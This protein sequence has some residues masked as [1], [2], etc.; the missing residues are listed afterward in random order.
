MTGTII[1]IGDE[2]LIGQVVNTNASWISGQLTAIGVDVRSCVTCADERTDIS[3]N[4]SH[5]LEVT[6]IV[7]VTGGLGPTDDDLTRGVVADLFECPLEF[8]ADV[9]EDVCRLFSSRGLPM[10][11]SNR[12]Q[13]MIPQGFEVL[14]NPVGTAPGFFRHV[15]QRE[16]DGDLFVLPGVPYEMKR[17]INDHVLP[18][19]ERQTGGRA[20]V[21]KTLLTTGI[22]ESWLASRLTD[23]P[24]LL[25]ESL[26]L[27]YLPSVHGVRLRI[28]AWPDRSEDAR[29][30]LEML[31]S[32]LR[33]RL[34]T[35]IYSSDN[36]TLE[37]VVGHLLLDQN[38]TVSIAESCTGG[39][40][41]DRL[42][43]VPGSSGYFSGS[44]TAYANEI[45]TSVLGVSAE[46]IEQKGA[47]SR[48]VAKEMAVKIR[49]LTGSDVS[50]S[51]TGIMGPGGGTG[52]K[53]VGT[54]WIGVADG[55][56]CQARR[57][58]FGDDRER[59]KTRA[60]TWAL[61]QLRILLIR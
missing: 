45:K 22:G 56:G 24:E 58:R 32:L 5:A 2:L 49:S 54:V 11:D 13:A 30:R 28:T 19:L 29:D 43:N 6:D 33:E 39:R 8:D 59:N 37:E 21:T 4:I 15:R 1:N 27:A 36:R 18:R 14:S 10:A 42:T 61:N 41:A 23:V 9:F 52:E 12:S 46:L 34:G 7:I 38:K 40:I 55:S 51:S 3:N 44:V 20:S 26:T 17:I 50:L 57:F 47:V 53:P 48:E 25:S 31:E 16:M 60:A 35:A